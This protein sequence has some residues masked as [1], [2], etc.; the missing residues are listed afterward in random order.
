MERSLTKPLVKS[1]LRRAGGRSPQVALL[2]PCFLSEGWEARERNPG[3]QRRLTLRP[4]VLVP[5]FQL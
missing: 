4:P 3:M 1:L 2:Q 5:R